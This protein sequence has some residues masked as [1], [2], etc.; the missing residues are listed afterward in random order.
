MPVT[1]P[2]Y[3]TITYHSAPA[4]I[5]AISTAGPDDMSNFGRAST[6][7]IG[8]DAGD[9]GDGRSREYGQKKRPSLFLLLLP[10]LL[11]FLLLSPAS[12]SSLL[13]SSSS[14]VKKKPG[15]SRPRMLGA[16]LVSLADQAVPL[17]ISESGLCSSMAEPPP[18]STGSSPCQL[19]SLPGP[20]AE[21]TADTS[22]PG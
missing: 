11:L 19:P 18:R 20:R 7:R 21:A 3:I 13:I 8:R 9:T 1:Q 14:K 15:P 6:E 17:R 12:P 16:G 5:C 2:T 4:R 22:S 10:F